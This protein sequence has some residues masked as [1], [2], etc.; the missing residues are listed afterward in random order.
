M[1]RLDT[2]ST[3]CK[4]LRM[5]YSAPDEKRLI[6]A[7]L[8]PE[9]RTD[10]LAFVLYVF[11]WGKPGTP[12]A[13]LHGPRKWQRAELEA[14]K[15]HM[16]ENV[17]RIARGEAPIVYQLAVAS[18]RGIGKSALVAWIVLWALSTAIGCSVVVTANTESQL[19]DKTWAELGKWHTMAVNS[20]WFDKQ[21]LSLRPQKWL[22][23]SLKNSFIDTGYY[24]A[25]AQLWSEEDPDAFAGL[26]NPNGVVLIMD[27]A[28]GIPKP[29]WS[30][31]EG[32][33]T[34]PVL[35][36]FWL[37]FSNPRRPDGAF[38][39][40]FNADKE[41]WRTR[42]IDSRGVEGTDI[43]VYEKI[44]K[45]YGEDSDEARVEVKGEFPKSG[46]NQLIGSAL[47]EEASTRVTNE[48]QNA[49]LPRIMGIDIARQGEDKSVIMMRQGRMTWE[50]KD[51]SIP[52][53]MELAAAIA[54]VIDEFRPHAVFIDSGNGYG[55][56]DRLRQL[57]YKVIDVNFGNTAM[58]PVYKDKRVEMFETVKEWLEQGGVIAPHA[59]L[60]SD[61]TALRYE[62]TAT[63]NQ[64]Y[65]IDKKTMKSWYKHSTDYGDALALTFAYPVAIPQDDGMM[66]TGKQITDYNPYAMPD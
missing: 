2:L 55:V 20:H 9:L 29:I 42:N 12:L 16:E 41:F 57:K 40:C 48:G 32:F 37:A 58:K 39:D 51:Y 50:P 14:I 45:K 21:A 28:S 43:A 24:Y 53:N 17:R 3:L 33:F 6:E 38:Y 30:V 25:Q 36:R 5:K 35:M 60:K 13:K 56:I 4:S 64:K 46:S 19:K 59:R 65:L 26:H 31:S 63:T 11:P 27:E 7:L 66:S 1:R 49:G 15:L 52:D 23:D 62:H 34:E 47:V 8:S 22:V 10:P 54:R 18:G 44:I 61:L